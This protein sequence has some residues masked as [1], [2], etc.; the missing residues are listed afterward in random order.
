MEMLSYILNA[1]GLVCILAA[2]ILKNVGMKTILALV[3]F[4]NL[5]VGIGY[6]LT[7]SGLNGAATLFVA[8]LMTLINFFFERKQKDLPIWLLLV[9]AVAFVAV[10][11]LVSKF[12]WLV[13]VA[14]VASLVFVLCISQKDGAKYRF[15]TL[16]NASLWCLYDVLV[17]LESGVYSGLVTH[18]SLWLFTLA[19]MLLYD[20]KKAEE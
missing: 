4:A 13:L 17:G 1:I 2:S 19:G 5:L 14:I 9:Y 18:L 15:W 20:R 8:C 12:S 3:F 11:L 7:G 10:N 16:I 6:L